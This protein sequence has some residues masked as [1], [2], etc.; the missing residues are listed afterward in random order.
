MIT[1]AILPFLLSFAISLTLFG[2]DYYVLQVKG[3]VKKNK[4]GELIKTKDMVKADDQ[5][6]FS[7]SSDAVA[8]VS[9]KSGRFILKPGKQNK[10]NELMSYVKD[11]LTPAS[12]RLSTRSGGLNNM[13]DL[14]TFFSQPILLL[15]ELQYK[16][17]GQSFPIAE[18]TFF[19]IQYQ[20]RRESINK[21]LK[22]N[23]DSLLSIN[24]SDLFK[25]DGKSVNESEIKTPVLHYYS[26]KGSV[27]ISPIS[28]TLADLTAV[29]NEVEVL[30]E[31]LG[32]SE[33]DSSKIQNEILNYLSEQ[34]GRVDSDNLT[35]WL[36]Q[37]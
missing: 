35:R 32:T 16:V 26:D 30:V 21:Q 34:Y 2:Q 20:Y 9:P 29:K 14:K 12:T 23:P 15:P 1:K 7:S 24:R 25:I 17:N 27:L 28:F 31:T 22:I 3:I 37:N 8:V 19:F 11:A 18:K 5:L 4:T 13:L 10:S 36:N 33:K 6:T